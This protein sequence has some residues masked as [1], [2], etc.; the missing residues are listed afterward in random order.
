MSK[1]I[2]LPVGQGDAFYLERS[3][4]RTLVDGGKSKSAISG[5][6]S[7]VAGTSH[8]D[9]V[10]CTHN[11]DDHAN[12][13]IG[14]LE[15]WNGTIHEVWVPGSWSYRIKDLLA[16]PGDFF[17][18]LARD[19][20]KVDEQRT[21]LDALFRDARQAAHGGTDNDEFDLA[22]SF[23]NDSEAEATLWSP[24]N[25]SLG[26]IFLYEPPHVLLARSASPRVRLLLAAIDAAFKIRQIITLAYRRGCRIRFFDFGTK[27][28]GGIPGVLEPVNAEE[29]KSLRSVRMSA[30]LYLSLSVANRES[31]V[32]SA[33]E[34]D[35]EPA[36]LFTADS[37]LNFAL[38]A[39]APSRVP[40]ITSP[41]HGSDANQN[42]Y[43]AVANWLGNTVV[44]EWIRSDC[45]TSKRPGQNFKNQAQKTCTLCNCGTHPQQAVILQDTGG[46][47]ALG[48]VV[49][50]CSC[51]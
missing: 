29:L 1:F 24:W 49:R 42:A 23:E 6:V 43:S 8:L 20:G 22:S 48:N 40:I 51:V 39:T 45:K 33:P 31:L 26:V 21:S 50:R 25:P 12:G 2:A 47:W 30:L 18:E 34:S 17:V 11:D 46:T 15:N 13:I 16:K 38:P 4:N 5:L 35:A 27:V 41:H 32:F 9:V 14:L 44:P 3:D 37:D 7:N 36:V 28:S 10:V 19:V